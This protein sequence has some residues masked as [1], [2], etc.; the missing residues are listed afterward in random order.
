MD[1]P[2][3]QDIAD[4]LSISRISVWKALND[5]PGVSEELREKV[6][7]TAKEIG[8]IKGFDNSTMM[9]KNAING[10]NA[11]RT[12]AAVVSRPE[13]SLFWMQI[14]HQIDPLQR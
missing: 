5:R 13:S 10:K 14:I 9:G 2:I 12:I 6:F 8:Y 1:K 3:M 7:E 11:A 4:A